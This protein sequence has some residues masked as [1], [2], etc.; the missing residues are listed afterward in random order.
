MLGLVKLYVGALI[1][2]SAVAGSLW[3]F[4]RA[5]VRE[6][7]AERWEAERPPLP[8]DTFQMVQ[9]KERMPAAVRRLAVWVYGAPLAAMTLALWLF[10]DA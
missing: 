6:R 8:R 10:H 9:W 2:L 7:A 4:W 3:L 5:G 1:G